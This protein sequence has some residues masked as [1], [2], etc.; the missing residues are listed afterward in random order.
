MTRLAGSL[1][2]QDL[3]LSQHAPQEMYRAVSSLAVVSLLLG[4]L[5]VVA[6]FDWSM[7]V[8]PLAGVLASVRAWR[9][10][11]RRSDEL[12]GM[13]LAQTGCALSVI[14]WAGGWAWLSVEY[15]TEVPAGYERLTFAELQPDPAK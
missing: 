13:A 3:S 12:T 15:A 10:T 9:S 11:V 1:E 6:I 14:F 4:L 2:S 8:V 7:A 5:S